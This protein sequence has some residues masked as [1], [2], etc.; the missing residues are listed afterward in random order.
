MLDEL[1]LLSI[2]YLFL[3]FLFF[4]HVHCQSANFHWGEFNGLSFEK[5]RNPQK[6]GKPQKTKKKKF[7]GVMGIGSE[8]YPA[9]FLLDLG[10]NQENQPEVGWL[11]YCMYNK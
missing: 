6:R 9:L 8:R 4:V 1:R 3:F 5:K 10:G 2:F 11:Q 7:G